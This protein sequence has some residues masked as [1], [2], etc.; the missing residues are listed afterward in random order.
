V[1]DSGDAAQEASRQLLS[2]YT[3]SVLAKLIL[4]GRRTGLLDAAAKA[5]STSADLAA[6]LGLNERYVREWL[7]AMTTSGITTYDP[8]RRT[9]VLAPA[10]VALLSGADARNLAPMA[11]MVENFGTHLDALEECFRSGGGIPYEQFRPEFTDTMDDMWR[12]I[13]DAQLIDGFLARAPDVI[14]KLTAGC[15]AADVGCGTGH[16]LNLMAAAFPKSTFVGYDIGVDGIELARQE[17]AAMGLDNVSFE[18]LDV[19]R[20]PADPPLDVVF[21]FD[22]IHDQVDPVTVL[23]RINAALAP[24][25]LFFMV[26][27]KFS[28]DVAGNIDNP[29]AP[30]YYG[31]SLMHCM[32]VSLAHGGA[33]LGTVWGVETAVEMLTAAGFARVDTLDCPRPQNLIYLCRN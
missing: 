5:P 8:A 17:A 21:V 20:L 33:G 28:S 12:R 32:T 29:F 19:V 6:G 22:A 16:A 24:D 30:L 14:A 18:V 13:Y 23:D 25:G 26:D 1:P 10:F 4:I 31:I 2:I 27:F 11:G 3:G 15:R 9:Y 7:G